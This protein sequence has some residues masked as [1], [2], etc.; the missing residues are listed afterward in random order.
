MKNDKRKQLHV[1]L[2]D[3]DGKPQGIATIAA[4]D[5]GK[6]GFRLPGSNTVLLWFDEGKTWKRAEESDRG[7]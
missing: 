1:V 2:L 4:T 5:Q 7:A 6:A 3:A